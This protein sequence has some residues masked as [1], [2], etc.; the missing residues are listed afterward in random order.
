MDNQI[1]ESQKCDQI[2][3][4]EAFGVST[5]IKIG[6]KS[7]S[8]SAF[9]KLPSKTKGRD[10]IKN[11]ENRKLLKKW[12]EDHEDCPYPELEDIQELQR[13]TGLS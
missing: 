8:Q 2:K 7:H 5:D 12:M 10:K 9:T 3:P 1:G 13:Q 11:R 4:L 6:H